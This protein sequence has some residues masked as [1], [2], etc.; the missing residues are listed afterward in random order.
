MGLSLSTKIRSLSEPESNR[1]RTNF[2]LLLVTAL[3][4]VTMFRSTPHHSN[5]G[6]GFALMWVF[7]R[8]NNIFLK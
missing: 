6:G 5:Y 4:V 3:A 7:V 1:T 8:S 2:C